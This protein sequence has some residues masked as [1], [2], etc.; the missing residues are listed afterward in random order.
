MGLGESFGNRKFYRA[1]SQ[2]SMTDAEHDVWRR[3]QREQAK[4]AATE[5]AASLLAIRP[6]GAN[7]AASACRMASAA[8]G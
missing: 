1:D 5:L 6:E 4:R 3:N 2:Q 7:R 8:A